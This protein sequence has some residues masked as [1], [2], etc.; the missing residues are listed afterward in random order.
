V[1]DE[2]EMDRCERRADEDRPFTAA[3]SW[4]VADAEAF[5]SGEYCDLL[6][7]NGARVPGWAQLNP[8]AHGDIKRFRR[9]RRGNG[10]KRL[11]T[12]ADRAH[13][14]WWCAQRMLAS[15]IIELVQGDPE[16]LS[17][18]QRDVLVPLEFRLMHEGDLTAYELVLLTRD[19][20]RSTIP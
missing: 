6:R 10:T 11:V 4:I 16:R 17:H 15:E 19:A 13:Q 7:R 3:T 9:I 12:H 5:L 8:I 20:L 1:E 14:M 2:V 18:V